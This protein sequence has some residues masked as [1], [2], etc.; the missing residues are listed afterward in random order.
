MRA[1]QYTSYNEFCHI[2]MLAY[3]KSMELNIAHILLLLIIIYSFVVAF[4]L[5]CFLIKIV[6]NCGFI[7]I[8]RPT[9]QSTSSR[10]K[11]KEVVY[12]S[13]SYIVFCLYVDY[14]VTNNVR[15]YDRSD[16]L[17]VHTINMTRKP[18]DGV[19]DDRLADR[20]SCLSSLGYCF[21]V[22]FLVTHL[23]A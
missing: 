11:F 12:S 2:I 5:Y 19:L 9:Y 4:S 21:Y 14:I 20:R 6:M 3:I 23:C 7:S 8:R 1:Q 16:K 15:R 22:F 17:L 18:F 13:S 10:R